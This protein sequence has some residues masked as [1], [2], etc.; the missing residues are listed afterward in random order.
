MLRMANLLGEMYVPP[1]KN[2]EENQIA[3][4]VE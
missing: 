1:H 4:G 2:K 3:L